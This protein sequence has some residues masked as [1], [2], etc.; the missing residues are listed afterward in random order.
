MK[1]NG[2]E[3]TLNNIHDIFLEEY[4]ESTRKWFEKV[5]KGIEAKDKQYMKQYEIEPHNPLKELV[6]I[7]RGSIYQREVEEWIMK[8]TDVVSIQ[9]RID[10]DVAR[11]NQKEYEKSLNYAVSS[12]L[13]G[14]INERSPIR[15]RVDGANIKQSVLIFKKREK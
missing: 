15:R 9:S 2:S 1:K 7:V 4:E 5:F 8:N 12:T 3:K 6:D 10:P 11:Y 13:S 14:F